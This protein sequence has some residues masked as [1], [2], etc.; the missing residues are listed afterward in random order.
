MPDHVLLCRMYDCFEPRLPDSFHCAAHSSTLERQRAAITPDQPE[1]EPVP[2]EYMGFPVEIPEPS[3][4]A[5]AIVLKPSTLHG[6]SW[7]HLREGD[8]TTEVRFYRRDATRAI[9]GQDIVRALAGSEGAVRA[10]WKRREGARAR[11][12][13]S[14]VVRIFDA[15]DVAPTVT[16]K[17]ALKRVRK[18]IGLPKGTH[19][20]NGQALTHHQ[21]ER[22]REFV[23]AQGGTAPPMPERATFFLRLIR[24]GE[25]LS[26]R[27]VAY[28]PLDEIQITV[29][30]PDNEWASLHPAPEPEPEP[31]NATMEALAHIE[32]F[33]NQESPDPAG[34]QTL[35]DWIKGP[36]LTPDEEAP[37]Y[38]EV[39]G[40]PVSAGRMPRVMSADVVE[41]EHGN[42]DA[43]VHTLTVKEPRQ[44]FAIRNIGPLAAAPVPS[45]SSPDYVPDRAEAAR[46]RIWERVGFWVPIGG[47]QG[48]E[49]RCTMP[50]CDHAA[51]ANGLCVG[52]ANAL[53]PPIVR[54]GEGFEAAYIHASTA[55]RLALE[56]YHEASNK[57]FDLTPEYIEDTLAAIRWR[58]SDDW[59]G[60][61][62]VPIEATRL[63]RG[64][65]AFVEGGGAAT[66]H[67]G[68][69]WA[70]L[71]NRDEK[72]RLNRRL[73][74]VIARAKAEGCDAAETLDRV[75][76]AKGL[77]PAFV[78]QRDE[79][80]RPAPTPPGRCVQCGAIMA[81]T[82]GHGIGTLGAWPYCP[83]HECVAW[84]Q[85]TANV[86]YATPPAI[87]GLDE[88]MR[89][90]RE[91]DE[92][93]CYTLAESVGLA[94]ARMG[95]NPIDWG[96]GP[97]IAPEGIAPTIAAIADLA[98]ENGQPAPDLEAF[99]REHSAG[100]T[101]V[102]A[103]GMLPDRRGTP[104]HITNLEHLHRPYRPAH[105][106]RAMCENCRVEWP[107]NPALAL[108]SYWQERA[109]REGLARK[110]WHTE[111]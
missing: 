7:Q 70:D 79:V 3:V 45:Q 10:A 80:A 95:L 6:V 63:A 9:V 94:R 43:F 52:C 51:T 15:A 104:P 77:P 20:F 75:R 26:A 91:R 92:L 96:D 4:W 5:E 44:P 37:I 2:R 76:M 17:Q 66:G 34:V 62:V 54:E 58:A 55:Y 35:L 41:D 65:A 38:Q 100:L 57:G 93:G 46:Y 88:I 16:Y 25:R 106:L 50:G 74:E 32:A 101:S 13:K 99:A 72:R 1:P 69:A 103:S 14:D 31:E 30:P 108:L 29:K 89:E 105:N 102:S 42:I 33:V 83:N 64:S 49:E 78:K 107:C 82:E 81:G 86:S 109:G 19:P 84:G 11:G 48:G 18:I 71:W 85:P 12:R 68:R 47:P 98:R 24:D 27:V 56:T 67:Q 59:D 53:T 39:A 61:D 23:V 111:H 97:I 21:A 8:A 28:A 90:L 40:E 73:L 22:V 87:L 110:L 36:I 60:R